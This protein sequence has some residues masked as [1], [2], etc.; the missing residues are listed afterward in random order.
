MCLFCDCRGGGDEPFDGGAHR[1][2]HSVRAAAG[3]WV[4]GG[5]RVARRQVAVPAVL[6]LQQQGAEPQEPLAHP[7]LQPR[8]A[9]R[10][11]RA[12]RHPWRVHA[13]KHGQ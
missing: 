5:V 7:L 1:G 4:G 13:S 12:Q 10:A 8:E 6:V 2:G 9:L 11:G 3:G